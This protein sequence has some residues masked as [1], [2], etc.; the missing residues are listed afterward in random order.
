LAKHLSYLGDATIGDDTNIGAGTITA[1]FDGKHKYKTKIGKKNLIGSN[2]VLVAP[3]SLGDAVK[4]GA[5]SIVTA[6][7]RAKKGTVLVGIPARP[8]ST[9]KQRA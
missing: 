7:T 3:V 5:G 2:T 4:T 8:I 1:N 9:R 6:R